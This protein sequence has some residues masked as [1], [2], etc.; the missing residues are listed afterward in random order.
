M[1]CDVVSMVI[2][3]I[4]ILKEALGDH[5]RL[6]DACTRNMGVR[7]FVA[8]FIRKADGTE[9]RFIHVAHV[10]DSIVSYRSYVDASG[11]TRCGEHHG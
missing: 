1:C 11:I 4:L 8:A 3:A 10:L 6:V 5:V 2:I 7:T 9:V